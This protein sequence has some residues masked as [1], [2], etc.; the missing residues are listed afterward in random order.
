MRD[1]CLAKPRIGGAVTKHK[2]RKL[3]R[4][5]DESIRRYNKIQILWRL[6]VSFERPQKIEKSVWICDPSC[7][8]RPVIINF[9]FTKHLV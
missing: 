1:Y 9:R 4:V 3:A 5:D 2:P 8:T 7:A 6:E